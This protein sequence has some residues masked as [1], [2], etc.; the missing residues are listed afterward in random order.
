MERRAS[1]RSLFLELG[2]ENRELRT[3]PTNFPLEC[4]ARKP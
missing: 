2:T 4:P 1:P 3:F